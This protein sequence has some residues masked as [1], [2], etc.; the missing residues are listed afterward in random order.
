MLTL[1]AL[2][3]LIA[4]HP[5]GLAGP[6]APIRLGNASIDSDACPVTMG[7]VNLSRD[8]TYRESIAVSC[9]AAIRKG[10]IMWEQ[11]AQLI[12]IGAESTTARAQRV[13]DHTQ[14]AQVLPVIS[15]LAE[16]GV[17]VSIETYSPV[18]ADSALRAGAQVVN[19]TG[20]EHQR[21]V[22]DLAAAHNATV[23]MCYVGAANVRQ[24][25]DAPADA[26]PIPQLLEHFASRVELAQ[27]AGVTNLVLDPGMGF[28]YGNLTDP[29]T[30]VRHQAKV[31]LNSYRLRVLGF[32]LCHALPHAFDLFEDQFRTAEGFFAVLARLG[33]TGMLR[34]HEV[35]HVR[36]V[37]AAMCQLS[38][39]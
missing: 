21:H 11:G 36:A 22:L 14:I 15:A 28:Y 2:A 25:S 26:D 30:R 24:I 32:P 12:D 5:E 10:K 31:L 6:V 27:S 34:T 1:T 37:A 8:S 33:Q 35:A 3:E 23:I 9:E 20:I 38:A 13:D 7:T 4:E 39:G 16:S 29:M 18:I 19:L 17:C